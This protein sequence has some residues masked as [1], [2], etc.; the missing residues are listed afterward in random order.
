MIRE[1]KFYKRYFIEFYLSLDSKAQEKIEYVFKLIRTVDMVPESF[2][3]HLNGTDGLFEIRISYRNENFRIFCCFDQGKIIVLLN[4]FKK[5]SQKTPRKEI[6]F[7]L[8]LMVQYYEEKKL[9][10]EKDK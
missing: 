3:K 10:N 6:D 7:A 1:I 4:S 9:K 5:K 2:L 8:R